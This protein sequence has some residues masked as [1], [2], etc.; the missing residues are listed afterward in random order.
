MG[1]GGEAI[2]TA[3]S[4]RS[5]MRH[6]SC[7]S[8]PAWPTDR[9]SGSSP[10]RRSRSSSSGQSPQRDGV[11]AGQVATAEVESRR[12]RGVSRSKTGEPELPPRVEQSWMNSAVARGERGDHARLEALDVVDVAEDLTH[13]RRVVAPAVPRRVPDHVDL[14]AG[15][16]SRGSACD[17]DRQRERTLRFRRRSA[18]CARTARSNCSWMPTI[19]VISNSSGV[20]GSVLLVEVERCGHAR[21]EPPAIAVGTRELAGHVTVGDD[22]VGS[23]DPARADPLVVRMA[24]DLDPADPGDRGPDSITV[25]VEDL[26]LRPASGRSR[27]PG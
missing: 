26:P 17:V 20:E 14:S 27:R 5:R 16:G 6:R 12:P 7:L 9:A 10:R 19:P 23:R 24:G 15:H 8:R 13:V 18:R 4:A 25:A 3:S 2:G 11:V 1:A 22:H 21:L